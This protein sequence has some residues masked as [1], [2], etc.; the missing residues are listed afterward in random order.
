MV[1]VLYRRRNEQLGGLRVDP[2]G[3]SCCVPAVSIREG[4]KR[5][6]PLIIVFAKAPRPG[7]VK[8]RLG[9]EPTTAAALY[10]EFVKRTLETVR[11]LRDEAETELSLDIP[12][13]AWREVSIRRT[14]QHDGDL[15]VRLYSALENGL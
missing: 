11:K 10:A 1:S 12:C 5:L 14:I 3:S 7:H 9:L 13:A 6:L 4:V 2:A 8:T 15:G